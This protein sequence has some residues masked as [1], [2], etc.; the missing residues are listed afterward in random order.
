[1]K[2]DALLSPTLTMGGWL[3]HALLLT[4]SD[5]DEAWGEDCWSRDALSDHGS[6]LAVCVSLSGIGNNR[7]RNR[8]LMAGGAGLPQAAW[9]RLTS[10]PL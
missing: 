6:L 10:K 2:A 9:R 7:R 4:T 8:G 3:D 5:R 1:M